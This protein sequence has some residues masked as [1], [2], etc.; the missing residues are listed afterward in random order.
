M[1]RH[2]PTM[3]LEIPA[4][5]DTVSVVQVSPIVAS[6]VAT[7]AA[8]VFDTSIVTVVPAVAPTLDAASTACTA[9]RPHP[10]GMEYQVPV[11]AVD[12]AVDVKM[13]PDPLIAGMSYP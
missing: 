12:P 7:A 5:S 2:P 3:E 9:G 1:K 11:A 6:L 8:V 10:W 13:I 4:P